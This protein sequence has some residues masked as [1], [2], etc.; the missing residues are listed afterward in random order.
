MHRVA[1]VRCTTRQTKTHI[2]EYREV[3]Y[4]WHPCFGKCIEIKQGLNKANGA[5]FRCVVDAEE[6][7]ST[8]EIPKWMFDRAACALM[9]KKVKPSVSVH[10]LLDLRLLLQS[11]ASTT[12]MLEEQRHSSKRKGDADEYPTSATSN[13]SIE[14]VPY[15][16]ALTAVAIIAPR[17]TRACAPVNGDDATPSSS[18]QR[19]RRR[20]GR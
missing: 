4:R 9:V 14:S 3:C 11:A 20:G 15:H 2:T 16:C 5:I 17:S 7:P 1:G 8:L 10:A 19:A 12:D 13:K 18:P 6:F